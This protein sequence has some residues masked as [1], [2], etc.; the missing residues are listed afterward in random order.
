M[1]PI[2]TTF[3]HQ[4]RRR[5]PRS[6]RVAGLAAGVL[7]AAIITGAVAL[8]TRDDRVP[9]AAAVVPLTSPVTPPL[10][11]HNDPFYMRF[12]TPTTVDVWADPLLTRY[13]S[14]TEQGS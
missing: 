1:E 7:I 5:N 14:R 12:A 6:R 4:R 8:A 2:E 13:G 10:D 3:E 9:P 11:E